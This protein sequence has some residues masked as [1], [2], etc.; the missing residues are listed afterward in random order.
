M[1]NYIHFVGYV[2]QEPKTNFLPSG[3]EVTTITV[4]TNEKWKTADG[5]AR[6]HT[7]W[8]RCLFFGNAARI[9][10]DYIRKGALIYVN[11]SLRTNKYHDKNGQ[12]RISVE[13]HVY[14]FQMLDRKKGNDEEPGGKE[15]RE[16]TKGQ[17]FPKTQSNASDDGDIPF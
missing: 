10:A 1:K 16:E 14:E 4:A 15:G 12:E 17:E 9:A 13:V 11:G 7:E 8:F 2:G 5:E 3:K 6:E